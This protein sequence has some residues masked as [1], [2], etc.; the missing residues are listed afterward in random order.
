MDIKST[1]WDRSNRAE[2]QEWSKFYEIVI[3]MVIIN[4]LFKVGVPDSLR[5]NNANHF[6]TI[7]SPNA[8]PCIVK[9]LVTTAP[10]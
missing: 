6:E 7:S 3:T 4:Y 10:P 8:S 9:C 5:R 1:E 2:G